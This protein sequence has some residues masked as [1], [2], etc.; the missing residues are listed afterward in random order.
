[1]W[2]IALHQFRALP[3]TSAEEDIWQAGNLHMLGPATHTPGKPEFALIIKPHATRFGDTLAM[4]LDYQGRP[5]RPSRHCY[6]Q[7]PGRGVQSGQL[8]SSTDRRT[9]TLIPL[10]L[11]VLRHEFLLWLLHSAA[12]QLEHVI[13][14]G[15]FP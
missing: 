3:E 15:R 9:V 1:M 14:G 11:Q 4:V 2:R 8:C 5:S 6:A 10:T 13:F 12:L 7:G